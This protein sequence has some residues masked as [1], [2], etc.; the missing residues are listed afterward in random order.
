MEK[1]LFS[2][3]K[4]VDESVPDVKHIVSLTSNQYQNAHFANF[5]SVYKTGIQLSQMWFPKSLKAK[6]YH[7]YVMYL[8]YLHCEIQQK[9]PY[10]V[11]PGPGKVLSF[12]LAEPV[13]TMDITQQ[14]HVLAQHRQL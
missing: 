5:P 2:Y 13:G 10:N 7:I 6:S 3:Q 8:V 4:Q 1:S 12:D 14:S 9:R 11:R